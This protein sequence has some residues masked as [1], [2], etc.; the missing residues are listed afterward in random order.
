MARRKG[1]KRDS[2]MMEYV[3]RKSK[4]DKVVLKEFAKELDVNYRQ[5]LQWKTEDEWDKKIKRKRGGQ[6]GNK[7]TKGKKNAKGNRGNKNASAP[8][9]N[10]NAEKDGAYS[11]IFFDALTDAEKQQIENTILDGRKALEEELKLLKFRESKIL[12]KIAYYESKPED[13]LYLNN[14]MDM[15]VPGGRGSGRN[16]GQIQHMGMYNKDSA[17]A[18]VQKLDEALYKVQGRIGTIVS[19]IRAMEDAEKRLEFEEKRLEILKMRTTGVV[20]IDMDDLITEDEITDEEISNEQDS[21]TVD[22][23]NGKKSKAAP[24]RRSNKRG[25][26]GT[27][28]PTQDNS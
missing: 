10:K 5:L 7:N 24:G 25:S 1:E 28:R 22:R 9:R 16:D 27:V 12:Q 13:E 23:S 14:L 21:S 19:S 3:A 4:G 18:R 2:V 11:T 17:F 20:D 8:L 26:A 6:P 15:R